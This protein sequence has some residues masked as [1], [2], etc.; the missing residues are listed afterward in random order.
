MRRGSPA[1]AAG[2]GEFSSPAFGQSLTPAGFYLDCLSMSKDQIRGHLD[3]LVL[4]VVDRGASHGYAIAEQLRL[5]SNGQFDLAE[6]SLYPALY[7]LEAEGFL[8]SKWAQHQG[9]RRRVY[10]V[11]RPG[12]AELDR[13]AQQWKSFVSAVTSV[14][15]PSP[16]GRGA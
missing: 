13:Q 15:G 14:L 5:S 4:S 2:A 11:T 6:G 3:L 16:M 7:R 1:A 8:T 12:K 9:R 10:S